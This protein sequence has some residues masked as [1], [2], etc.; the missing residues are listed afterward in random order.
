MGPMGFKQEL[1]G[2]TLRGSQTCR[3]CSLPVQIPRKSPQSWHFAPVSFLVRRGNK[4]SDQKG[5]Q[6][7]VLPCNQ[8][9]KNK[10]IQSGDIQL[11]YHYQ[12]NAFKMTVLLA[13]SPKTCFLDTNLMLN[14]N[15][16]ARYL[17][18]GLHQQHGFKGLRYWAMLTISISS[19]LSIGF[20]HLRVFA[21]KKVLLHGFEDTF[22]ISHT[23]DI[24][25]W[26]AT[27]WV[28]CFRPLPA[29]GCQSCPRRQ[30]SSSQSW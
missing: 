13:K 7:L 28:E 24:S 26:T 18:K 30:L 20:M 23:Q 9:T 11:S 4:Q 17:C 29:L 12:K 25:R 16:A 21:Q 27:W 10:N 1:H 5:I 22:Q 14:P 8:L 3:R 15:P 19:P 6:A 2:T